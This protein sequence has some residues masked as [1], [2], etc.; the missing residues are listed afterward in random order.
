MRS[1]FYNLA[2][3]IT[4]NITGIQNGEIKIWEL[5]YW[6][7]ISNDVTFILNLSCLILVLCVIYA[8]SKIAKHYIIKKESL[9]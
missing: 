1:L 5:H 3:F 7:E 6:T 4:E 9:A 8:G 2:E